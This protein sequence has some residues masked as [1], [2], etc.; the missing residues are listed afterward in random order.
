MLFTPKLL[1]QTLVADLPAIREEL[2]VRP[3]MH[4]AAL[5][6]HEYFVDPR[7]GRQPMSNTDCR[8]FVRPDSSLRLARHELVE[9]RLDFLLTRA[10]QRGGR[11][12]EKQNLGIFHQSACDCNALLLPSGDLRAALAKL[13]V[14]A[15]AEASG[16]LG[17]ARLNYFGGGGTRCRVIALCV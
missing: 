2:P 4:N 9:L 17:G 16:L 5:P 7:Y 13:S 10:V 3:R 6:H 11:F 12:V 8:P 1:V 15:V 14:V